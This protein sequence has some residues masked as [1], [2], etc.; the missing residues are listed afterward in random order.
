[1]GLI[2]KI[3]DGIFEDSLAVLAKYP[4]LREEVMRLVT[5][6]LIKNERQTNLQLQTHIE[7][8]KSFMNTNHPDFLALLNSKRS[9]YELQ[10]HIRNKVPDTETEPSFK[11]GF[12]II[13]SSIYLIIFNS[14]N[15]YI[16]KPLK[17]SEDYI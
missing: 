5:T 4:S 3:L 12:F 10:A 1:M 14:P 6:E 7:A 2:R 9:E 15:L 11:P 8:Q 13:L 17:Y 16:I